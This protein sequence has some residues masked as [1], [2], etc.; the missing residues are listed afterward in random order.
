[1]LKRIER[2]KEEEMTKS[3]RKQR[4]KKQVDALLK[5]VTCTVFYIEICDTC[6][7]AWHG[8]QREG[9]IFGC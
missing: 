3:S 6:F 7:L 8:N 2:Q 9:Q 5:E 1:M 4:R